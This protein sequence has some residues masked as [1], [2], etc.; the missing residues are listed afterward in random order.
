MYR[1]TT[2]TQQVL[3]FCLPFGGTLNPDNRWI[4]LSSRIPW[5]QIEE[6]YAGSLS[7]SDQG[8]PA[9]SGR[10]AFGALFIQE[11]M[12]LTDRET[13]MQ[14]IENPYIQFFLGYEKYSDKPPFHH[15]SMVH[16]RKRFGKDILAEINERI[17]SDALDRDD[18]APDAGDSIPGDP[19]SENNGK[20]IVDATCTPADIPYPTDLKLL[21]E[22]RKKTEEI[23]DC[24]HEP[25]IGHLDKPRTYRQKANKSY[26]SLA[27]QR[28]PSAKKI[29]KAIRRQLGFIAR[30]LGSIDRMIAVDNGLPLLR[31]RLYKLLLVAHEVYRQQRWMYENRI[32]RIPDRIINMYQPHVRPIVRGKAGR[33][34]EFGAKISVSLKDGFSHVDRLSWDAYNESTDLQP[35]I[36]S[37]K[38]RYGCYPESVHADKIYRTVENRRFCQQHGIRL[39][40]PSLGRRPKETEA[41]KEHLKQ[42]KRQQRQDEKDRQAIEGKFGQGKRRFTLGRIMAK[43]AETSESVIMM[44][45]IVMN[46]EKILKDHLLCSLFC[47]NILHEIADKAY[48]W[49]N[50]RLK[51]YQFTLSPLIVR[52]TESIGM[53]AA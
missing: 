49:A 19:S 45:F 20:H 50:T 46:L 27:K 17:I 28:K 2:T 7:G 14:V 33:P 5:A 44:S 34:V 10:I 38:K 11:R 25:H 31:Q 8:C 30:N 52:Q 23:I 13:V 22:V 43:L 9:A 51:V 35:Q 41:N 47:R 37:Y 29:R 3:D 40:G 21:N 36:R 12:G 4:I 26:L 48:L 42:L 32:H 39:S 53:M 16:F 1:K 18:D 24:L 6:I 15:T